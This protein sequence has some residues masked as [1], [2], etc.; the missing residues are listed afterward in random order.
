MK[1]RDI[2]RPSNLMDFLY[3]GVRDNLL[4]HIP[5]DKNKFTDVI[6]DDI[7]NDYIRSIPR[8]SDVLRGMRGYTIEEMVDCFTGG[9][10]HSLN[11][12]QEVLDHIDSGGAAVV[13]DIGKYGKDGLKLHNLLKD[14]D[15]IFDTNYSLWCNLY[16]SKKHNTLPPHIDNDSIIVLQ[17]K[18]KKEW[19]FFGE[20]NDWKTGKP[21][22]TLILNEGDF[23]YFGKWTPHVAK[24]ISN[25]ETRHAT[26]QIPTK[27]D[28]TAT[29]PHKWAASLLL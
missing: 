18:G 9:E 17:F 3:N 25:T 19:D 22:H 24:N 4:V 6:N 14:I 27:L 10:M 2:I 20:V 23:L 15:V 12:S 7:V 13:K 29:Y 21:V 11:T 8:R 1:V 26:F 5:G 28:H 16:I